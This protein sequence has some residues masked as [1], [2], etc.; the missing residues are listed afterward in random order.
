MNAARE[1][2]IENVAGLYLVSRVSFTEVYS[3][4]IRKKTQIVKQL[5]NFA[6]RLVNGCYNGAPITSQVPQGCDDEKC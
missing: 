3:L 1:S 4:P 2:R 6:A 5:K